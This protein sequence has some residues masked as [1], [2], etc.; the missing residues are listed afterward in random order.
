MSWTHRLHSALNTIFKPKRL[1]SAFLWDGS[2]LSQP[3]TPAFRSS[4]SLLKW[5]DIIGLAKYYVRTKIW[6]RECKRPANCA[7][8]T[9][10]LQWF[11]GKFAV[12]IS[13]SIT[14]IGL[15][16]AVSQRQPKQNANTSARATLSFVWIALFL[17]R[18]KKN[19]HKR[20]C[21]SNSVPITICQQII[22]FH[23]VV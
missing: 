4:H 12:I 8:N 10:V 1:L 20:Y 23:F 18:K 11:C 15:L 3:W 2:G 5:K 13:V 7:N 16:I 6:P 17:S 19:Y 22:G 21:G 9:A 14:L